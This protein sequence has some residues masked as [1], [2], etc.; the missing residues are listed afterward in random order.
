MTKEDESVINSNNGENGF[1]AAQ[2]VPAEMLEE[3]K[4]K[5]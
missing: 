4:K 3:D 2:P 5:N 1:S